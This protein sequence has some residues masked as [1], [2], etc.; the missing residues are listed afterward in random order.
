MFLFSW[1]VG[2]PVLLGTLLAASANASP[3]FVNNFSF[4]TLPPGGSPFP[5]GTGCSFFI[6][7][8]PG[9]VNAGGG[10]FVPGAPGNTNDFNSIPDGTTV[11]YLN[12]GTITQTVGPTVQAGVTYT[13]MVDL[14]VRKNFSDPGSIALVVNGNTYSGTGILPSSG[15]WAT[16]T[17]TYTG[18]AADIG[19]AI[20]IQ[21][22]SPGIQGEFDN[23]RLSDNA[24]PVPEPATSALIGLGAIALGFF[25]RRKK[26]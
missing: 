4:E 25:A 7:P 6:D 1:R 24:G 5:C 21:L 3:I 11:A 12:G 18:L 23:V 15:N 22:S 26:V 8:I 20:T 2:I 17:A 13:L 14:G 16:F 19:Q 10:Q 9:W